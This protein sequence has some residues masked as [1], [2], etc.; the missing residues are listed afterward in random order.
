MD[1]SDAVSYINGKYLY[2]DEIGDNSGKNTNA[3]EWT[4]SIFHCLY[5]FHIMFYYKYFENIDNSYFA[6]IF[7]V[8]IVWNNSISFNHSIQSLSRVWLFATPCTSAH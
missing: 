1:F 4:V 3:F 6:W 8:E 2:L 5:Y 7:E